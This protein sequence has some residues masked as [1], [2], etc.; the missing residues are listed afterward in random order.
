MIHDAITTAVVAQLTID[1]ITNPLVADP[2]DNAIPAIIQEGPL[3][4]EPDPADARISVT[5]HENDPDE[6]YKP[7]NTTLTGSW[8]DT[9]AEIE[10]GAAITWYRRFTVKA[11]CLLVNTG[12]DLDTTRQI[13]STVRDRIEMSLLNMNFGSVSDPDTGEYV[14]KSVLSPGLKGEMIQAGGP[15]AYDYHIKVRFQ[16]ETTRGVQP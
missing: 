10:C 14:A 16:V 3:Q 4:S 12:E 13:A 7:A 1:L 6:V 11:R 8:A 5:V 2:N 15:E 9:V